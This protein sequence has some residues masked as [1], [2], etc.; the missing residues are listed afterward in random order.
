MGAVSSQGVIRDMIT[1]IRYVLSQKARGDCF[2][3]DGFE[4]WPSF[5][6][7]HVLRDSGNM[8]TYHTPSGEAAQSLTFANT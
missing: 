5:K 6:E 4:G 8:E 2:E 1:L 3:V 7:R